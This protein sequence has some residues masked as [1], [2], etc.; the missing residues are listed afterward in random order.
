MSEALYALAAPEKLSELLHAVHACL[1]LP[2]QLINAR[3]AVLQRHG[4]PFAYCA[5]LQKH[6][7]KSNECGK[8]HLN[9]GKRAYEMGESYI[10]TCH[11]QLTHI[12]FPLVLRRSLL[13]TVLLGPFLMDR[14][15]S[16]LLTDLAQRHALAPAL[17]LELY[18][19][20]QTVPVVPPAKVNQI[21]KLIEYLFAPLLADERLLMQQRQARLSQQ[22][23]IN[24]T[25]QMYKGHVGPPHS[26]P[27]DKERELLVKVKTCD[28]PSAK[29]ILNDL[30]AYVLLVDGQDIDV[31][32]SR[33]LELTTLLSRVAI[34][35]GAPTGRIYSLNHQ[36]LS[37][38]RQLDQLEDLCF[39]LQEIVEAFV[40]SV[41]LP[42]NDA[43]ATPIREAVRHI[44]LHY[45]QPLTL[46]TV[47]RVCGL[48][49]TYFSSLF[50]KT[51]GVHYQEYLARVRVEEAKHLLSATGYP[52]SQIAVSV[53]YSDQSSFTK[54]FKRLT[55][56][57]PSQYR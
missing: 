55:G 8:I 3:G 10:F 12:A 32:R 36:F 9:A 18:D 20:L 19:E 48:S 56:L 33:A 39:A 27:Y 42:T 50:A 17:C 54:A 35:G 16:T 26:Y 7:W 22:S 41:S 40:H 53:G 45:G 28:I 21:S 51:M 2:A 47:A 34:E 15:D 46:E 49:P 24:E 6:I 13:G 4:A 23:H 25:I 38:L 31:I 29:A 11:S 57:T 14:A 37:Q 1:E 5:L 44:A 30:L 43:G 52:V